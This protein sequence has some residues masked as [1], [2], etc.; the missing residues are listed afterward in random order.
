[1]Q[2]VDA[3][4]AESTGCAV[5][6]GAHGWG[7]TRPTELWEPG[8]ALQ[9]LRNDPELRLIPMLV[10]GASADD[11]ERLGGESASRSDTIALSTSAAPPC[12]NADSPVGRGRRLRWTASPRLEACR[13][14]G[15]SLLRFDSLQAEELNPS[16]ATWPSPKEIG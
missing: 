3:A 5:F 4:L 7:P 11:L 8:R 16:P 6:L 12:T 10:K 15:R 9:R 13:Q 14:V 1:M 2:R